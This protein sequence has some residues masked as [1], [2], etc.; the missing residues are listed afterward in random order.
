MQQSRFDCQVLCRAV[1]RRQGRQ[2]EIKP[3]SS[4]SFNSLR[5]R[6]DWTANAQQRLPFRGQETCANSVASRSEA[7]MHSTLGQGRAGTAGVWGETADNCCQIRSN[8][9]AFPRGAGGPD[10]GLRGLAATWFLAHKLVFSG[11]LLGRL[12]VRVKPI[13]LSISSLGRLMTVSLK[14]SF[15]RWIVVPWNSSMSMLRWWLWK[16]ACQ[17]IDQETCGICAY[18]CVCVYVYVCVYSHVYD[19]VCVCVCL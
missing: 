16:D 4:V 11:L 19:Y 3:F 9:T 8:H 15:G 13:I 18:V 12:F 1:T 17:K 2:V 10:L 7:D 5:T 14:T 6:N